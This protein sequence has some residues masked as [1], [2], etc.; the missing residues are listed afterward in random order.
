MGAGRPAPGAGSRGPPVVS[1]EAAWTLLQWL[2]VPAIG[3]GGA[4]L[5][6]WL[7]ELE[8]RRR[9]LARD[10][11]RRLDAER[12]AR[13]AAVAALVAELHATNLDAARTYA[14]A[15]DVRQAVDGVVTEIRRLGERFDRFLEHAAARRGGQQ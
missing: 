1:W 3:G 9:E 6:W 5:A 7:R 12:E 8:G 11:Y 15:S 10:L 4:V 14:T 13:A 2:A